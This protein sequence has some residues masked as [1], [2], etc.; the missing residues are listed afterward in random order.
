MVIII[1][2]LTRGGPARRDPK[3][4]GRA[5]TAKT[6]NEYAARVGCPG[7]LFRDGQDTVEEA[8]RQICL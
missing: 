1:G 5:V 7:L 4:L 2:V 8:L 3:F 6:V